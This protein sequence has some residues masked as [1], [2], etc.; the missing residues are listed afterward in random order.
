[1]VKMIK[2][3]SVLMDEL[4]AHTKTFSMPE[5][6]SL[7]ETEVIDVFGGKILVDIN[8]MGVGI[9]ASK[10]ARSAG[11]DPIKIKSGDKISAYITEAENEEGYYTLSMKKATQQRTWQNFIK[12][13][14]T[15]ETIKVTIG[16]ANKGGLLVLLEG[17]KGFIPVSQLA[18]MHYPRVDG[19]NATEILSRLQKLVGTVMDVKIISIDQTGGKLILSEKAASEEQ[20][21]KILKDLKIGSVVHGTISGIVK[22]GIFVAFDGLEG[23]VH[24][25][26]IE[27]GHVKD[28]STYGRIGNPVDVEIIGIEGDKIS[29]SMKRLTSDPWKKAAEKYT[30]GKVVNGTVDR[31]TQFGVFLKLEDDISGLIHLSELSI[32][33][34]KDPHKIVK[35]GQN[36]DV[37]II[38]IDPTEHRI[39]LSLKALQ[40][41]PKED[42]KTEKIEKPKKKKAEKA[43]KAE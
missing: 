33:Q 21:V 5:L 6:G 12:A 17:I 16:E 25:S 28:P 15:G 8:G 14:E 37:K 24:I 11:S 4:L 32:E 34:V 22:F 35:P 26:E 40:E 41:P 39:G 19:A 7:V 3:A 9:I 38:A 42:E 43:E 20:R 31:I 27:W 36:V 18:P 13:Y 23:L 29:L 10:E 30:V 1:M 2:G